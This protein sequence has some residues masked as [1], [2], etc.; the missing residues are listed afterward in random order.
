MKKQLRK[1]TL[2]RETLSKLSSTESSR[3]VGGGAT[4]APLPCP[5]TAYTCAYTYGCPPTHIPS[6]TFM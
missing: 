4:Q 3:A 5:L 2:N 1:L 6:C